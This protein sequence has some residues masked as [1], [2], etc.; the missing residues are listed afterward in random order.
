MLTI[1]RARRRDEKAILAI[2]SELDLAREGL[3]HDNFHV[4]CIDGAIAGIAHLEEFDGGLY[5]SAVGVMKDTQGKDVARALLSRMLSRTGT[6]V[7][8]HTKIPDFFRKFG[9][10][11]TKPPPHIPTIE[12]FVCKRCSGAADC[13]CMVR[14]P[15]AA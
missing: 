10:E 5:L 1:R 11:I 12:S 8:L 15:N 9:F 7:Y 3:K 4:A 2:L 14:T 13:V 6:N